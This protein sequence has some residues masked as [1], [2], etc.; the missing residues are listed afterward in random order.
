M[1][2]SV[3]GFVCGFLGVFD[4]ITMRVWPCGVYFVF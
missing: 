1:L 3:K 4:E 2:S